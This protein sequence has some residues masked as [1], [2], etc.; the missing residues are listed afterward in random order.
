MSDNHKDYII[1]GGAAG[2]DRLNTLS[3]VLRPYTQYLL[4]MAGPL[5]SKKVLDLGSG[6][7]NVAMMIGGM[8]GNKG[9]VTA[10]DFDESI[11]ALAK[12][13]AEKDGI[14]NVQFQAESAY[15]ITYSNEFDLVY[16]RFLLSHL[17]QPMDVLHKMVDA[18]KPGARIIVEDVDFTGHFS[19]PASTAFEQYVTLYSKAARQNG[20]NPKIGQQ[21]FK[22]FCDAGITDV[23]FDVI[24]PSFA[25]GQGKW[26][27]WLTLD[28]I[29][30]TLVEHNLVTEEEAQKLLQELEVFTQD[31]NTIISMP[32][33]FR[34]WGRK[35]A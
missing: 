9:S 7:G 1:S 22:M 13:Q 5:T 15:D 32:R 23:G 18:V 11:V 4:E 24:Q 27:G 29:K 31:P 21:L 28:R 33:I 20:Q 30:N 19:Y 35:K 12:K 2:K 3:N 17:Q 25:T 14:K 34:V 26:M 8:V 6:G 10:I 16:S